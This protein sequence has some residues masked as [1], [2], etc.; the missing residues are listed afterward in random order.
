MK[1]ECLQITQ[2]L[3]Q[4]IHHSLQVT[5]RLVQITHP[6]PQITHHSLTPDCTSLD[7]D[8]CNSSLAKDHSTLATHDTSSSRLESATA[9]RRYDSKSQKCAIFRIGG[10][11]IRR[12]T[13]QIAIQNSCASKSNPK[14]IPIRPQNDSKTT[15]K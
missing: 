11:A 3:L 15:P 8:T 12:F 13:I 2:H 1:H 4:H 6:S 9:I 10:L 5:Y 7:R 14:M